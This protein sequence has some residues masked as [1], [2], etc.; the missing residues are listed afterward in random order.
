MTVKMAHFAAWLC[1]HIQRS[2]DNPLDDFY[3]SGTDN[4]CDSCRCD[5]FS[6]RVALPQPPEIYGCDECAMGDFDLCHTCV[7]IKRKHC[8]N[9]DHTLHLRARTGLWI[10][11]KTLSD[12]AA[13]LNQIETQMTTIGWEHRFAA[14]FRRYCMWFSTST[15]LV[16]SA[17]LLTRPGDLVVVLFG[18]NVPFILRRRS[19]TGRYRVISDCYVDGMM[20]GQALEMWKRGELEVMDVPMS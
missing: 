13:L 15:N 18:A 10:Q 9:P 2:S 1:R 8:Y 11:R 20:D 7:L 19:D 6:A 3:V 14:D 12:M 16:G 4:V 5:N 17:R